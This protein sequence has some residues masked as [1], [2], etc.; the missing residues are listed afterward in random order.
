MGIHQMPPSH[1][2]D[3]CAI[4]WLGILG[5]HLSIIR[6]QGVKS[7]KR[8][9]QDVNTLEHYNLPAKSFAARGHY[10]Q[11]NLHYSNG[12]CQITPIADVNNLT[13]NEKT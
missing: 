1:S 13:N 3:I 10:L 11:N 9:K 12:A 4:F 2:I 7:N 5:H 8:I 6:S